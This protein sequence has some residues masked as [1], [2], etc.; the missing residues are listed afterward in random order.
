MSEPRDCSG[1]KQDERKEANW[2]SEKSAEDLLEEMEVIMDEMTDVD[3]DSQKIDGYLTALNKKAPL[4]TQFDPEK[5]WS[6]F[7]SQHAVL[8]EDETAT[9]HSA[10]NCSTGKPR[11]GRRLFPRLAALAA[12]VAILGVLAAQAA[13]I[14]VLGI[15]GRWTNETFR[16]E[17]VGSEESSVP[18][19]GIIP[20]DGLS[21][22]TLQAALDAYDIQEKLAP[23][24]IPEGYEPVYIDVTPSSN[25]LFFE[26]CFSD[27]ENDL[28]IVFRYHYEP[29]RD[30]ATAEKDD[31]PVILYEKA[32][33][34]H[35]IMSN[36]NVMV[37]KWVN[38]N[39]ECTI[40]GPFT[41]DELERMI[42][43]IY[44]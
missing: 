17:R 30:F 15:F 32:E 29:I 38:N 20:E 6:A 22:P 21:Y 16:F 11:R 35:Y 44:T 13:G 9:P 5:A 8:F 31:T 26:S 14:D 28:G 27:G 43:S 4:D 12:A 24:W 39:C 2:Y 10:H 40:V 36:L 7:R 1:Q 41:V 18:T 34:A 33:I 19:P 3:Y 37:V 25:A 42:D 23:T